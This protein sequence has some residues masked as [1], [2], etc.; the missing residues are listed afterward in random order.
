MSSLGFVILIYFLIHRSVTG[1]HGGRRPR[2]LHG[3]G[4]RDGATPE[5]NQVITS[6]QEILWLYGRMVVGLGATAA[7]RH[8]VVMVA[9]VVSNHHSGADYLPPDERG[10]KGSDCIVRW[11]P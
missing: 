3:R 8:V 7:A 10:A 11:M 1:K 5:P 9:L 2:L 6:D 4:F